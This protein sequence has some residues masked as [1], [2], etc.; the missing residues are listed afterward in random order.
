MDNAPDTLMGNAP[1]TL[2]AIHGTRCTQSG[3]ATRTLRINHG[4]KRSISVNLDRQDGHGH[5]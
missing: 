4:I 5:T 2:R 3:N 1:A